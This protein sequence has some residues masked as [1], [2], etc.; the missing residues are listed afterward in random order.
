MD[1]ALTQRSAGRE[2][3]GKG[4]FGDVAGRW[5]VPGKRKSQD[6]AKRYFIA[7][8]RQS[9]REEPKKCLYLTAHAQ[10]VTVRDAVHKRPRKSNGDVS[11]PRVSLRDRA[12]LV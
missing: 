9:R 3:G 10:S 1:A 4:C 6:H 11:L 5:R 2:L 12:G 7:K 8:P